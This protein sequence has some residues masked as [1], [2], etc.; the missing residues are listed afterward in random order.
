MAHGGRTYTIQDSAGTVVESVTVGVYKTGTDTLATIYSSSAGAALANPFS[1]TSLGIAEWFAADGYYDVRR[2]KATYREQWERGV[3]VVADTTVVETLTLDSV[4]ATTAGDII[5]SALRKI[6]VYKP[7]EAI[8][9]S[10]IID[11]LEV[12]NTMLDAW[13]AE[14][15]MIPYSRTEAFALTAGQS[16][17]TIGPGGDF[18]TTRPDSVDAESSFVRDSSNND[19]YLQTMTEREYNQITLKSGSGLNGLPAYLWY[20]PQYP[21]GR[22]QFDVPADGRTL[23]LVSN[24]PLDEF[25]DIATEISLP[26]GYRQAIIYNLAVM[27]ASEYGKKIPNE[28][29]VIA[30]QTK[31]ML[32][33]KNAKPIMAS[34]YETVPVGNSNQGVSKSDFLAGRF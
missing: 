3:Q 13:A 31:I 21:L 14:T 25:T 11:N 24:K 5:K 29:G 32:K 4:G 7:G 19:S 27:L 2:F 17:Y 33:F 12:L 34:G 8:S 10:E 26:H 16:L 15:L 18:A 22:I 28:V 20:K 1:S 23:Y 6:K 30:T 9:D